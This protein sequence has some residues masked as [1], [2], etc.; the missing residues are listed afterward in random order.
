MAGIRDAKAVI[1]QNGFWKFA[2]QIY[3]RM[4]E[5]N[6]LVWASALAYSWLFSLFPFLIFILTLMPFLP[7]RWKHG[8]EH[9]LHE[10]VLELPPK[11]SDMVWTS[12]SH[13]PPRGLLSIGLV[14]MLWAASSGMSM[15]MQAMDKCWG[16]TLCRPYYRQRAL[17]ILLTVIEA[18]LI[19]SVLILIPVG[20]IATRWATEHFQ[21]VS[22]F[23]D[24]NFIVDH[25]FIAIAVWQI[26]RFGT[27]LLLMFSATALIY[28]FGPSVPR[29][30]YLLTPGAIFTI[31]I[32]LIL[33]ELFRFYVNHFGKGYQM[34]GALGGVAILLLFFYIDAVVLLIGAEI[35]SEIENR[36]EGSKAA[37]TLRAGEAALAQG[38]FSGL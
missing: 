5:N 1:A 26:V 21:Q 7:G 27:A 2:W 14:V 3:Q 38:E 37:N 25:K 11:A 29:P 36:V 19:L 33:G 4:N 8:T 34:Y 18:V 6:L 31:A 23:F 15:T 20:T 28:H 30:F 17:A 32:W 16:A 9:Y 13:Q 24:A 10:A 22:T 12:I 35:N